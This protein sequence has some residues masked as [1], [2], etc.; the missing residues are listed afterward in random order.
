MVLFVMSCFKMHYYFI[1]TYL[2]YVRSSLPDCNIGWEDATNE[3]L[4][5]LW[6]ETSKRFS[7]DEAKSFCDNM[8]SSLIEIESQ[9]QMTFVVNKLSTI[10][11]IA[12][13]AENLK[14]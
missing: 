10:T 9:A 5:H 8:D 14:V 7:F 6:F 4:G 3:N 13:G 12:E 1:L 11:E 2:A